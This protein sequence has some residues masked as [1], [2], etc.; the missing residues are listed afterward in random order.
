MVKFVTIRTLLTFIGVNDWHL[1]QLD[2]NNIFL[3]GE[4]DAYMV[5][6]PSFGSKGECK[7]ICKLTKSLYGVK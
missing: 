3:H 2:V 4:L 6:P 7:Q 1:A 5:S